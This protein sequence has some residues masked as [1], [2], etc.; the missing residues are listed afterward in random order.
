VKRRKL[1]VLLSGRG[2]NFI[3]IDEAIGRGEIDAEIVVVVSNRSD[4]AGITVAR[5]R[6]LE[7][8]AIDHRQFESREEHEAAV[9]EVIDAHEPDFLCLA[10]YMR[11]LTPS[12]VAAYPN[13][14]VNIHPS[15]LPSFPGVDAQ[16]QAIEHG[17]KV[18]GCTVHFVDSGVDTGPIIVQ[19][20]IEILPGETADALSAR[21]LPIEH[22]AYIE[23]LSILCSGRY[24]ID[25]RR[26]S[27]W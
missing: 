14:I 26:I 3:S 21:L 10:G 1:A 5:E 12:F 16:R 27:T 13:R 18:T 20:P 23:A 22:A 8:H 19:K 25:G 24:S 17:V 2:S 9:R 11:R 15:L 4:A 6:G 7:A